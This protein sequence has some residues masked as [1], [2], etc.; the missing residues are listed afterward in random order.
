METPNNEGRLASW[1]MSL[2][3]AMTKHLEPSLPSVDASCQQMIHGLGFL[4]AEREHNIITQP[5]APQSIWGTVPSMQ[6]E[7]DKEPTLVR[8]LVFQSS[9]ASSS[10][11]CPRNITLYAQDDE[12]LPDALQRHTSQSSVLGV[13][14]NLSTRSLSFT[15]CTITGTVHGPVMS[16]IQV[17]SWSADAMI[18]VPWRHF[19]TV[20]TRS[21]ATSTMLRPSSHAS[22]QNLSFVLSPRTAMVEAW[23][24]T[25]VVA[26][27]LT[28]RRD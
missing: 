7:P 5:M 22:F 15:Y 16:R 1:F 17:L 24:N 2:P 23:K 8:S 21:G 3:G 12:Y 13:S 26:S 11:D 20:A 10:C 19:D 9:F 14:T 4:I 6:D 27:S 28:G 18:Q 25:L